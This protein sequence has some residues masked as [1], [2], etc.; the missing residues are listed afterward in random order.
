MISVRMLVI[1]QNVV[2]ISAIRPDTPDSMDS[3]PPGSPSDQPPDIG[4]LWGDVGFG[5]KPKKLI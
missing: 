5:Y 4:T 1:T 3:T 2:R